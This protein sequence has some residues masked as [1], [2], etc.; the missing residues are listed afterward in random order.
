MNYVILL[1]DNKL[2]LSRVTL[3]ETLPILFKII[4]GYIADNTKNKVNSII[5]IRYHEWK[6]QS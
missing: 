6:Y 2:A 1:Q 3:S 5:F 4:M